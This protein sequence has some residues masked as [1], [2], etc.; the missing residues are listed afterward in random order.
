MEAE[1]KKAP[2][3]RKEA[4]GTKTSQGALRQT[5][6]TSAA[7]ARLAKGIELIYKKDFKKARN[8]LTGLLQSFPD[9]PEILA[10]ARSYLQICDRE[11]RAQKKPEVT[12]DQLY[13]L[14]VL[15]HNKANYNEAI[16]YF[17]QSL[18]K[19][20][21]ADYI[22]YSVAAS[23]ARNGDRPAAIEHLRKAIELNEDSRI[24]ARNDED[25]SSL[26]SDAEFAK[27]LGIAPGPGTESR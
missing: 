13:S 3:S 6:T 19:Q 21:D 27:L 26:G 8:E 2:P 1:V 18:Q 10:R 22:Y 17:R 20:P 11:E 4:H 23:L 12:E 9:E 25:F 7:L 14:G 5:K 24:F 15:E 16:S